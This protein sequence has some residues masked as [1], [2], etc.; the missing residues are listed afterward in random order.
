MA[1][2]DNLLSGLTLCF[3]LSISLS[4]SLSA[5]SYNN[6]KTGVGHRL[7]TWSGSHDLRGVG[8]VAELYERVSVDV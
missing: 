4:V 1:K 5:M 8:E 3:S 2:D 6:R 7:H